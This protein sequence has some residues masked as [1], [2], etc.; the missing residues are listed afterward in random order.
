MKKL[1]IIFLIV[2]FLFSCKEKEKEGCTD[3]NSLNYD[4][5]AEKDD[6]SCEY[7]KITFYV[8]ND[9]YFGIPITS[10][11]VSVNGINI[12]AATTAYPD[13]PGNCNATGTAIYEFHNSESVD[14]NSVVHLSDGSELYGS[15]TVTPNNSDCIEVNVTN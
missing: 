4:A 9:S 14:W 1:L 13:G 5:D 6:G 15:G 11:D 3:P 2:P 10:V 8:K 7:R 12:G